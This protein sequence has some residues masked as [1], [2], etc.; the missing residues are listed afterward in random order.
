MQTVTDINDVG[1]TR[2]KQ[3]THKEIHMNPLTQN[4]WLKSF[5]SAFL[6]LFIAVGLG[7]GAVLAQTTYYVDTGGN[8]ANNGLAPQVVG[9][10]GPLRTI[11]AALD[12][13][14]DGDIVSVAAGTYDENVPVSNTI[15]FEARQSGAQTVVRI[16]NLEIDGTDKTLTF[17]ENDG[18]TFRADNI[19]LTDGTIEVGSLLLALLDGGEIF[20]T[21]DG[22][23]NG[24]LDFPTNVNVTYSLSAAIASGD[25]LPDDLGNGTLDVSTAATDDVL[26]LTKDVAVGNLVNTGAGDG[27][28][29]GQTITVNAVAA[30]SVAN[31]L[32]ANL[33]VN[34]GGDVTLSGDVTGDVTL[35]I[36]D[37]FTHAFTFAGGEL[38]GNLLISQDDDGGGTG[39][40]NVGGDL[41][42]NITVINAGATTG[43]VDLDLSVTVDGSILTPGE[44]EIQNA[45]VVTGDVTPGG[46]TFLGNADSKIE[47]KL[48]TS[49]DISGPGEIGSVDL[50]SGTPDIAGSPVVLGL[51]DV[52]GSTAATS[53]ADFTVGSIT[54]ASDASFDATG[55]VITVH[56]GSFVNI[57]TY[58]GDADSG[59]AFTGDDASGIFSPNPNFITGF[60]SVDKEGQTIELD[61]N[62][63]VNSEGTALHIIDG[64]L[65][66][67]DFAATI[68]ADGDVI[69]AAAG[70]ILSNTLEQG[71]VYF[72]AAGATIAG[73]GYSNILVN[74]AGNIELADDVTFGGSLRFVSG[75]IEGGAYDISPINDGQ[76]VSVNAEQSNGVL[77]PATFN[78]ADLEYDLQY[79]GA[80]TALQFM[81]AELTD[82]VQNVTVST[83]GEP[84]SFPAANVTIVNLTIESDATVKADD[85][86]D[87]LIT[88]NGTLIIEEDGTLEGPATG[89]VTTVELAGNAI[90]HTVAGKITPDNTM[91]AVVISADD[92]TVNGSGVEDVENNFAGATFDVTGA[93]ASIEG[94]QWIDAVTVAADASLTL[95]LISS[96]EAFPVDLEEFGGVLNGLVIAAEGELTLAAD[97]GLFIGN[98][99]IADEGILTLAGFDLVLDAGLDATIAGDDAVITSTGGFLVLDTG[100][101]SANGATIPNLRVGA[102][103]ISTDV[104]VSVKMEVEGA[105]TNTGG[106]TLEGDMDVAANI[107]GAGGLVSNGG[108]TITA[109]FDVTIELFEVE[110]GLVLA[111][112]DADVARVFTIISGYTH[113]SGD[114]EL[115]QNTLRLDNI[116]LVLTAGAYTSSTGTGTIDL[117]S[118]NPRDIDTGDTRV[119][120]PNLIVSGGA[121][122]SLTADDE[123]Y[124][125][126]SLEFNA[127]GSLDATAN[128]DT[129]VILADG[130]TIT[131]TGIEV[132]T[133][134]E[135][136]DFEGE[137]NLIYNGV[138][139]TAAEAPAVVKDLTIMDDG[140]VTLGDDME[141]TGILS[142]DQTL[143]DGGNDL[144]LSEG[145]TLIVE[146]GIAALTNDIDSNSDSYTVQYE[147]AA[148]LP[149]TTV[150]E[151]LAGTNYSIIAN[152]GLALDGDLDVDNLIVAS[153][154]VLDLAAFD[155]D[156]AGN[157]SILGTLDASGA[158]EITFNGTE[159]QAFTVASAGLAVPDDV[160]V[161]LNNA[162]GITL[163][164]GNLTMGTGILNFTRGIL[165][166]GDN[167]VTLTQG[168]DDGAPTQGFVRNITGGV[169]S[170][171]FGNVRKRIPSDAVAGFPGIVRS[172]VDFPVGTENPNY[173]PMSLFFDE[174]PSTIFLTVSHVD[175]SPQGRRG[176]DDIGVDK[177]PDFHWRVTSNQ[178]LAET[179]TYEVQ[180]RADGYTLGPEFNIE[181]VTLINRSAGDPANPDANRWVQMADLY[182]NDITN[183]GFPQIRALD[184]KGGI[185]ESTQLYTFGLPSDISVVDPFIADTTLTVD[186]N[187][188]EVNL[189][190]FFTSESVLS[191]E[192][193]SSDDNIA[194]AAIAGAQG[195]TLAVTAVAAGVTT[196]TIT[197]SDDFG[198]SESADFQVTVVDKPA[199]VDEIGPQLLNVGGDP[200][201]IALSERFEGGFGD[202]TYAIVADTVDGVDLITAQIVMVDDEPFIQLDDLGILGETEATLSV[203]DENNSTLEVVFSV[204]V[205]N[206]LLVVD[207]IEDLSLRAG[208]DY[209]QVA[210]SYVN[211]E[212]D[213]FFTG[214][215]EPVTYT[216]SSENA[217]LVTAVIVNDTLT[218]QTVSGS[219]EVD[220]VVVSITATD[221]FGASVSL[222][223]NV[224][225]LPALGDVNA[226][227]SVNPLDASEILRYNVGLVTFNDRQ[228]ELAD[229]NQDGFS[230]SFDAS[231]ILRYSVEEEG[232]AIPFTAPAAAKLANVSAGQLQWGDMEQNTE[233]GTVTVPIIATSFGNSGI[234]S[235]DFAANFDADQLSVESVNFSELPEGWINIQNAND[236]E[237]RIAL[238]G[239]RAMSDRQIATVT[240][241]ISE[242]AN[243]AN[244]SAQGFVN[245][246]QVDL[247]Q[248]E[249]KE[250]P[251]EFVLNQNYPNPFNPT[252]KIGFQLPVNAD[253][254]IEIYNAIG[255]RVMTLVNESMTAGVHTVD[256]DLSRLSSG[257]YVYRI[258]AQSEAETFISTRKM[259]LIK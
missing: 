206:E 233:E 88:I 243:S 110:D 126:Y 148:T 78:G 6:A 114:V 118:T 162:A 207:S 156:A 41:T 127:G 175:E 197:A 141:V 139:T 240:F 20:R 232:V 76:L 153:G 74:A 106:I 220:T 82:N 89:E 169:E 19:V 234:F 22:V 182:D 161:V 66:L 259:T 173:R 256:A 210:Q 245:T 174:L 200:L 52:Q 254:T 190:D 221:D 130:V 59:I 53:S 165:H 199:I 87:R 103:T 215:L 253:V 62:I 160:D 171:V 44:V 46:A 2:F 205:G 151:A 138:L 105:L 85:A 71:G 195:D 163:A 69:V 219:V 31:D 98:L 150:A 157:V 193:V 166:T 73:E 11:G 83:S 5:A 235:V 186:G 24:S 21:E 117:V 134:A 154:Q 237:L 133:L 72:V 29:G 164:G 10:D 7:A 196:I 180:T 257:V 217:D 176:L 188:L 214:G 64:T 223:V 77:S 60:I 47:G 17:Q 231:V 101:L 122:V 183:D 111:S 198:N 97:L 113:V 43:S 192:A 50:V 216:V 12:L 209:L 144:L 90:T 100:T 125:L 94:L 242:G 131:R 65:D 67:K 181:D 202:Y 258:V 36:A 108:G 246:S 80:L 250:I 177:Y 104:V 211:A 248:L 8:D 241:K 124:I 238:A 249:V 109:S 185:R 228:I 3:Q 70:T 251:A 92:V 40:V 149:G 30:V 178:N 225:P 194:T 57:G 172:R 145:S 222:L 9:S 54:I 167:V 18:N 203:T 79:T 123:L 159:A 95:E 91:I 146:S 247:G 61:N 63:R 1:K 152:V 116:D 13:V 39:P 84:L 136:P 128:D 191:Y 35:N 32:V 189:N 187:V 86:A 218:I 93:G 33:V 107:I 99:D 129:K 137:I 37:G 170:Y 51:L 140:A 16:N 230:N 27:I 14:E 45:A 119:S 155:L 102:A 26:T 15:T 239:T 68:G 208:D 179:I 25:E 168:D 28:E 58:I 184:A 236:G 226:D 96:G 229:V 244:I 213:T 121:D 42:G 252:T 38:V 49:S 142:L 34:T 120:V 4:K 255:Q 212:V 204:T 112:D 75:S 147:I 48:T 224:L 227:G 132:G 158:A 56:N 81:G 143:N 115:N 135:A 201:M 55:H 23:L